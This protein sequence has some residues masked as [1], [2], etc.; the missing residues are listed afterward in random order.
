MAIPLAD[1]LRR[2]TRRSECGVV[3]TLV[4]IGPALALAAGLALALSGPAAAVGS[5]APDSRMVYLRDCASC[6]AA[7]ATGS[8]NGPSLQGVGAAAVDYQV[9]TGRMPLPS[10]RAT[11]RRRTPAYDSATIAALVAYV[12]TIAPGG[13]EIPQIDTAGADV[14]NG[15]GL[16]RAQCAACHQWAGEGGALRFGN[17]PSLFAATP[18]QVAEAVRTGP[19]AMPVFGQAALDDTQLRD[20]VGYVEVLDHPDDAGGQ[21]LWHLG[22]LTEGAAALVALAGL[23][24]VLRW[25]GTRT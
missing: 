14:A 17:A 15:G 21:P 5:T 2:R 9:S 6:H 1:S 23:V 22:P 12:A 20:V 11:P 16:Y 10:P 13:P 18:T 19:G 4:V 8:T 24:V 7:D 3:G 25:M